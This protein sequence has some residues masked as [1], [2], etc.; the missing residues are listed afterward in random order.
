MPL[1]HRVD[2]QSQACTFQKRMASPQK[3]MELQRRNRGA[4]GN[5]RTRSVK[6]D[7]WTTTLESRVHVQTV[8]LNDKKI[9][10]AFSN[11]EIFFLT[12]PFIGSLRSGCL[13]ELTRDLGSAARN[14]ATA[15]YPCIYAS[16]IY[17][18]DQLMTEP[19]REASWS[20]LSDPIRASVPSSSISNIIMASYTCETVAHRVHPLPPR[21]PHPSRTREG[22]SGGEDLFRKPRAR[23]F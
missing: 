5:K 8:G 16:E 20:K 1:T 23:Y 12:C 22:N 21:R 19:C 18:P 3:D 14:T 13:T 10:S 9:S 7:P 4:P 17:A 6:L 11:E 2:N 15:L